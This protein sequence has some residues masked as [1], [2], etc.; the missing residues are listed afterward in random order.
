MR[1][2]I[3]LTLKI[4]EKIVNLSEKTAQIRLKTPFSAFF[5]FKFG[6]FI[7][8]KKKKKKKKNGKKPFLFLALN[9]NT[10]EFMFTIKIEFGNMS[11]SSELLHL[12]IDVTV[13]QNIVEYC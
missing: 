4:C 12:R 7:E 10:H 11:K 13:F 1:I 8:K 3:K 2:Q 6:I 5:S 9:S